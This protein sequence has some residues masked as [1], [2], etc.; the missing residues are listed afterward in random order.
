MTVDA[1][2]DGRINPTPTVALGVAYSLTS[3]PAA[4]ELGGHIDLQ[5]RAGGMGMDL[6]RIRQ[7]LLLG[8]EDRVGDLQA[9]AE[10]GLEGPL[11][12]PLYRPLP[13]FRC[14]TYSRK[15]LDKRPASK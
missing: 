1:T 6:D 2:V 7:G 13:L 12:V 8:A 3:L 15:R 4:A 10:H 14:L 11:E 5:F 9:V